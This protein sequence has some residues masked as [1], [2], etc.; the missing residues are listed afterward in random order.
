MRHLPAGEF[1]YRSSTGPAD[2]RTLDASPN[3]RSSVERGYSCRP[4]DTHLDRTPIMQARDGPSRVARTLGLPRDGPSLASISCDRVV[5]PDF[6]N[7]LPVANGHRTS[8][9]GGG[10]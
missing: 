4:A 7:G 1:T 2:R 9:K 3:A 10:W 8:L 5:N 6:L